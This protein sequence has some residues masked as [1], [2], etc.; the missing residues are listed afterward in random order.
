[1]AEKRRMPITSALGSGSSLPVVWLAIQQ[2]RHSWTSDPSYDIISPITAIKTIARLYLDLW[3]TWGKMTPLYSCLGRHRLYTFAQSVPVFLPTMPYCLTQ[4]LCWNC[5]YRHISILLALNTF[6]TI[7]F[8]FSWKWICCEPNRLLRIR[9]C[10]QET[11]ETADSR[12]W[13]DWLEQQY[14]NRGNH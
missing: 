11:L 1:M 3:F 8:L 12:N 10:E 2:E 14:S 7:F 13:S 9:L 5:F 4:L 6:Q